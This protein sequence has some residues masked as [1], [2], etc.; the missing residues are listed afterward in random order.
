MRAVVKDGVGI[1]YPQ[2]FLDGNNAPSFLTIDDI[3]A[4]EQLKVDMLLVSLKKVIFFNFNGAITGSLLSGNTAGTDG[5]GV[6]ASIGPLT[7]TNTRFIANTAGR[8]G[9]VAVNSYGLG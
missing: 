9:G 7:I 5:G 6:F 4:T 8:G 3:K 1:F 2:G